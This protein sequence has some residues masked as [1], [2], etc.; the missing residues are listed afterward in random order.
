[1]FAHAVGMGLFE[2]PTINWLEKVGGMHADI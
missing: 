2:N 1:M